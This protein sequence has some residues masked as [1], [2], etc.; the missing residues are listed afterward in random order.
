MRRDDGSAT[1]VEVDPMEDTPVTRTGP[2]PEP[3][4][5]LDEVR[6]VRGVQQGDTRAF[7]ALYRS[8]VGR[9]YA[10]CRRLAGDTGRAEDW[11]QDVFVQVW[12]KIGSYEGRSRF[13]TWLY[14]LATNRAIDGLRADVRRSRR[15]SPVEDAESWMEPGPPPR[16][17]RTMD[18]EAAIASLPTAARMVFVLH[19]VEGYRHRDIAEMTG[20]AEGT[21]KSQLFRARGLLR[22]RLA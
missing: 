7:E 3:L 16:P 11:T 4:I 14:R 13:S 15:E 6:L 21:S 8:H 5:D 18:L 17:E 1:Q 20:M 10:V 12:E 9:V 2:E 19:D 22:E